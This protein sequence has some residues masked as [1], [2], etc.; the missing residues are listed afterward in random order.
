MTRRAMDFITR[1]RERRPAVV[2]A[3]VL[4]QAALALYRARALRQHVW[5]KGRAARDPLGEGAAGSA[6]GVRRLH[7]HALLPQ[8]VARR[9]ARKGDPDLYGPDQADRRP[10]GRA[11]ALPGGARPARHHH[12]RVHLRSWRLSRRSLDGRE[13]SVPR[14]VGEDPADRDRSLR[15]GRR[16]ARHRLRCAGRGDRPRA[17]LHRVFRRHAARPYPRGPLADAAAARREARHGARSC[18]PNTT[19]PCRTCG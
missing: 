13:G 8:H 9:G 18:S 14:A 5:R 15:V 19:I 16:D 7:G 3:S 6:S 17:D 2:P 10:D 4:H 1:G 11:D 12:D